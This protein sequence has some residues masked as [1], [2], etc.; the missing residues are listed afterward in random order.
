MFEERSI[1][2]DDNRVSQIDRNVVESDDS[3][4]GTLAAG[5]GT[6]Q[7]RFKLRLLNAAAVLPV[8][9]VGDRFAAT[10][11][12]NPELRKR[13]RAVN[14]RIRPGINVDGLG[15]HAVTPAGALGLLISLDVPGALQIG[16]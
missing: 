5:H 14:H 3:P 10:I 13:T 11:E 1:F 12:I 15:I 9:N 6:D 16:D 4:F 2:G 8:G 7:L